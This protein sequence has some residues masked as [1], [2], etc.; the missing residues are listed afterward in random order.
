MF[1]TDIF[2]FIFTVY[3]P[4]RL[5]NTLSFLIDTAWIKSFAGYAKEPVAEGSS[6]LRT[7]AIMVWDDIPCQ[8]RAP[9]VIN[10]CQFNSFFFMIDF[11]LAHHVVDL[12]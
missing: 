6:Q 10:I 7:K 11:I 1:Y 5:A 12:Y 2:L 4:I 9:T 3:S 8:A